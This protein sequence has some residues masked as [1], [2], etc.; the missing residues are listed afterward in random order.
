MPDQPVCGA[1]K[2]L[3]KLCVDKA[4][5]VVYRTYDYADQAAKIGQRRLQSERINYGK[6]ASD[7]SCP[8]PCKYHLVAF[9]PYSSWESNGRHYG[10]ETHTGS[11]LGGSKTI[12]TT[13]AATT[14]HGGPTCS[15]AGS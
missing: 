1:T 14:A 13:W 4:D 7:D 10:I 11:P 6:G 12:T 3:D 8:S 2:N 15:L 5:R 9:T